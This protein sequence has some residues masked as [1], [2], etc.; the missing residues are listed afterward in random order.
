MQG[1]SWLWWHR[2]GDSFA[3]QPIKNCSFQISLAIQGL[4]LHLPVP[5][6]WV[7][8]LVGEAKKPKYKTEAIL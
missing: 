3:D 7:Q 4:R 2:C 1:G 8:F 6:V 5:E